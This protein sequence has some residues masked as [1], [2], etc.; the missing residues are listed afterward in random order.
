MAWQALKERL[1]SS[2]ILAR[3]NF[4]V[5]FV[6]YTD[7]SILGLGA[8]LAQ[9]GEDAKEHVIAYASKTNNAAE[10]NYSAYE[11]DALAGVWA[12]THF[13]P[14]VYGRVF[15]LVT[16][17]QP[18]HWLLTNAKLTDKLARWALRLSEYEIQIVHRAGKT[19]MKGD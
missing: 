14:Y 13:R 15:Q 11:G 4:K 12:E 8:V 2:P 16:D 6:L 9:I 3:P 19:H 10:R 5:P 17:H 1:A 7:W 18:L